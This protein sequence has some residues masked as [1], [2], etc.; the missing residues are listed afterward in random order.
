MD[1]R[2]LVMYTVGSGGRIVVE[3]VFFPGGLGGNWRNV[4][5]RGARGGPA[6]N[7]TLLPLATSQLF[8][9]S[10]FFIVSPAA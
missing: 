8:G 4:S 7:D 1:G 5:S 9:P 6:S 2:L 3:R 10:F